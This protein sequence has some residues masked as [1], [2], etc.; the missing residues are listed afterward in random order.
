M[1][2][3]DTV[4]KPEGEK[5]AKSASN[6]QASSPVHSG[7]DFSAKTDSV[8]ASLEAKIIHKGSGSVKKGGVKY[9]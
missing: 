9:G 2:Q 3:G 5:S 8:S 6:A 7:G 4:H 1:A